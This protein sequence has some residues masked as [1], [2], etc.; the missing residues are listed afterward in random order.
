VKDIDEVLALVKGYLN[1][2]RLYHTL[3]VLHTG[4]ILS[5]S[6]KESWW[7]V[8]VAALMHDCARQ[9]SPDEIRIRLE[10]YGVQIPAADE[11]FP[12]LW[13]AQLSA[14]MVERELGIDDAEIKR[15]VLLH[16]TGDRDM[17]RLEKI[18]FLADYVE[19]T[20]QFSAAAE[21]RD[22]AYENLEEAFKRALKQK[23]D[24]VRSEGKKLHQR[25]IRALQYYIE[26][27][28]GLNSGKK[29]GS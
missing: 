19:P 27:K 3:G 26:A 22:L 5:Q 29:K 13:H 12:Q 17:S 24:Y 7:R 14:E 2:E 10:R 23:M 16:P 4:L 28:E 25:S 6:H 9:L 11:A 21:I 1:G 15:A 18:I 8:A 20:R